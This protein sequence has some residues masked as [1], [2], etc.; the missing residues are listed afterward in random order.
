MRPRCIALL[1]G[2]ASL[3]GA[4]SASADDLRP[5]GKLL[6]TGGV[7]T[8]EGSGGGGLSS[9]ATITGYATRDGVGAN[10]HATRVELPDYQF[11]AYGAAVGLFD[12]VELSYTRQDFDT[13]GTGAKLGLGQGF[14]FHQDVLG[15][16]VKVLGDAVYDQDTWVPQVAVGA[17]YKNAAKAPIVAALGG[18]DDDGI[19]YYVSATK[20]LLA[21]S[22]VVSGAVRATKANQTG[23]LGFG[24]PG[25]NDDYS[26]QFEGSAG[27]LL[28]KRL[29]V[30]G[31]YRSKPNNLGLK[32]DD[33]WD[34]FAAYAVSKNLSVT[35][36]YADLGTIATFKGQRGLYLSLQAGF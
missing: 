16:K 6:L 34:L 10:V 32:E 9:W 17:Q 20:V 30:G 15:V 12:R 8:V 27:V 26:L 18:Q 4:G 3:L 2:A 13:Q 36:G 24:G 7:T 5:S 22:M 19:D 28:S 33:W 14:T 1:A 29:L 11:R 25:G 23:L 31:E 21:E 35:A